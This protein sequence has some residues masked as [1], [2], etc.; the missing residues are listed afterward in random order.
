MSPIDSLGLM[1]GMIRRTKALDRETCVRKSN[2]EA[3]G[4]KPT[5]GRGNQNLRLCGLRSSHGEALF[6]RE[7]SG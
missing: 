2:S 3:S 7:L 6:A 5:T 4:R 1:Q